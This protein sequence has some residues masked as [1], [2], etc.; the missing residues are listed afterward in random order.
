MPANCEKK[1]CKKDATQTLR[2]TDLIYVNVDTDYPVRLCTE[3]V[4]EAQR[5]F[6]LDV[7]GLKKWL[8][9]DC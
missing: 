9:I 6:K 3:H 8:E 1:G 2:I 7:K 4:E 5:R